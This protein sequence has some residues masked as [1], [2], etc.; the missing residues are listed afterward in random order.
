ML[1]DVG[2]FAGFVPRTHMCGCLCGLSF[3]FLLSFLSF[4]VFRS[5]FAFPS[6]F[7]LLDPFVRHQFSECK[8]GIALQIRS[9]ANNEAS[10]CGTV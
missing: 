6:S 9:Y 5:S 2:L 8:S 4:V 1:F 3:V 10:H 7:C